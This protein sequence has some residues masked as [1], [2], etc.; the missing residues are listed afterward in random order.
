[1]L[2]IISPSFNSDQFIEETYKSVIAQT[3]T[4]WEWIIV[5]DGSND[6]TNSLIEKFVASDKRI[7]FYKRDREPKGACTCRNI[8][9][10]KAKYPYISFLDTDDIIAPH[11]V[12]QRLS[13]I[14]N[15]DVDFVA[16]QAIIFKKEIHDTN[17]LWNVANEEKDLE[18]T[19]KLNPVFGGGNTIW[20]KEAFLKI[21]G[22]NENMLI[23]QD[24]ELDVR[25]FTNGLSYKLRLDLKPDIYGRHNPNSISRSTNKP[26]K[27]QYA[28]F[29]FFKEV[30]DSLIKNN[31][32]EKYKAQTSWLCQKLFSDL[33][34]DNEI[35]IAKEILITGKKYRLISS[36]KLIFFKGFIFFA[37]NKL[38]ILPI[39]IRAKR[40]FSPDKGTHGKKIVVTPT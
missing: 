4:N 10:Q 5:D 35:S 27:K 14:K 15:F 36:T 20:K 23:Y 6:N 8:G 31:L 17:I 30:L 38:N 24:I 26:Y 25:A 40:R 19:I 22:W 18:R 21:G 29:L 12:E 34:C 33:L 11:Y 16:F 3:N 2:S 39:I 13:E 37:H 32:L 28:K 1:M 9:L 7:T